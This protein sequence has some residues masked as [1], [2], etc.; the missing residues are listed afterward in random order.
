MSHGRWQIC[1]LYSNTANVVNSQTR[2]LSLDLYSTEWKNSQF[3]L[4]E[5]D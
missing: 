4:G 2:R 1:W 5:K 3:I